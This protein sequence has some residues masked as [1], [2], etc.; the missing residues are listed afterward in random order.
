MRARGDE[1][2]YTMVIVPRRTR[3]G[4]TKDRRDIPWEKYIAFATNDSGIDIGEYSKRRGR[5]RVQE[6]EEDAG[7]D[8]HPHPRLPRRVMALTMILFNA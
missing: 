1:C 7:Q 8:A 3:R 2:G 4:K 6:D 5:D